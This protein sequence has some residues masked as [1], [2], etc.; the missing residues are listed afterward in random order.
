MSVFRVIAKQSATYGVASAVERAAS[1]FLLP[2]YTRYLSPAEYG[3][4]ELLATTISVVQLLVGLRLQEGLFYFYSKAEDAAS[5]QRT[6]TTALAGTTLLAVLVASLG[7]AGGN[8][9]SNLIFETPDYGGMFAV[10]LLSLALNLVAETGFA[11]L[12]AIES[13]GHFT[14]MTAFR[15]AVSAGVA[16]SSLVVWHLG[17]WALLWGNLAGAAATAIY[18]ASLILWRMRPRFD[19]RLLMAQI[20]F[21]API[22]VAGLGMLF[23]HYGDRYFLERSVSLAEIGVYALAYKMAMI[24]SFAHGPFQRHWSAQMYSIVARPDGDEI[25]VRVTTYLLFVLT[26]VALGLSLFAR[27]LVTIMAP[28]GY[29]GA[30]ALVPWL[31]LAY[32]VRGFGDHVKSVFNIRRRTKL[33]LPVAAGAVAVVAAAYATLIPQFGVAGAVASTMLG[34]AAFAGIAYL[35][36]QRV[37]RYRFE[38][39]RLMKMAV[40]AVAVAAGFGFAEPAGFLNQMLLGAGGMA[41]WLLLLVAV[42]FFRPHEIEALRGAVRELRGRAVP[43]R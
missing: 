36:A 19:R 41:T 3:I 30:A 16:V 42:R 40:L 2:V 8:W 10:A 22:G 23:L 26:L 29:R 39:A 35:F 18:M 34:F 24:V 17:V 7:F 13:A 21:S 6:V 38:T 11:Y 27:P 32:V 25:Y 31:S 15:L 20:A 37:H 4:L 43:S 33:H 5:R 14:V 1:I 9:L 28:A 12:R